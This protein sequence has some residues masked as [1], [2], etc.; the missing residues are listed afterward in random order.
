MDLPVGILL[1]VLRKN[2]EGF[3]ENSKDFGQRLRVQVEAGEF[4]V[5]V[6]EIAIKI[7]GCGRTHSPLQ[8]PSF[9]SVTSNHRVQKRAL[10]N[11]SGG[12]KNLAH[13]KKKNYKIVSHGY[14]RFTLNPGAYVT[15]TW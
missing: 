1:T 14:N 6:L 13:D 11:G 3:E 8:N 4:F 7:V 5:K 15:H 9:W 10:K 12:F 2:I